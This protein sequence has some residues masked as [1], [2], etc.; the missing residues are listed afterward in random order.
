MLNRDFQLKL[1]DLKRA[2][3]KG[4]VV[5]LADFPSSRG[6]VVLRQ[7]VD[8]LLVKEPRTFNLFLLALDA[9]QRD[10]A[11]EIMGYFQIAG[12]KYRILLH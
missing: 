5:G 2:H 3:N 8:V 9:L 10:D 12:T 6:G 11:N 7:D 1:E 4:I